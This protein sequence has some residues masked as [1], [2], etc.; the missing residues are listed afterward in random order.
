MAKAGAFLMGE[1]PGRKVKD[2]LACYGVTA[3]GIFVLITLVLIFFY[4]LYVILPIFSNVKVT[5]QHTFTTSFTDQTT[6]YALSDHNDAIYRLSDQ[7]VLSVM[8]ID[9]AS[10]TQNAASTAPS[11]LEQQALLEKTTAIAAT[12]P[13]QGVFAVGGHDGKVQVVKPDAARQVASLAANATAS[14]SLI[15]YPFGEAPLQLDPEGLAVSQLA[16]SVT[17]DKAAMIGVTADNRVVVR[18]FYQ[19]GSSFDLERQWQ[20]SGYEVA[21]LPSNIRSMVITPDTRTAY[22]LAGRLVYVVALGQDSG[23]VRDIVEV[24]SGEAMPDQLV[25]L[26]GAYSL[27]I[28]YSDDTLAQWFEILKDEKRVLTRT[29]DFKLAQMPIQAVVPEHTRK[30]FFALQQNGDLSAFYTTVK[31]A[32]YHKPLFAGELPEQ[33]VISPRADHLLAANGNQWQLFHVVNKHPEIGIASLWQKIWYEGYPEPD[34]VWQSTSASDEFEPKLSL[35]PIVFGTFKAAL[36]AL[37]FAI[38]MALAGA[39]YTAYFM[40]SKMRR[41]VKP[42]VELMEALPTVILGFL[43]GIWLAPI[44]EEYLAGIMLLIVAVPLS[45]M[46]AG[47]GWSLLPG[48]WRSRIPNGFHILL[49]MPV[50]VLIGYLCFSASPVM[51]NWFFDGDIRVYLTNEWGIGYDQRNTL[52][53]GIAM[54]F[55]VIPTIFSIAEDAIFSVPGHLTSGSLALGATP[56]QTLTKVV[57]LTASPG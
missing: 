25:P 23:A 20:S 50:I 33:L 55:A 1:N 24:A 34:Y 47:V 31:G 29:R 15:A 35:V 43:A 42:T 54:G 2:K 51:E 10:L 40:S 30:G 12:H 56:W 5:Q 27:L 9:E 7:G 21:G 57:L 44:V 16:V 4:L 41:I 6:A 38:P 3:G 26:S 19:H 14:S 48:R 36:Y 11:I 28:S 37:L 17:N 49:L 46:L 45:M 32:I 39:I 13:A 52:V 53:V 8:A 22:V 18:Q